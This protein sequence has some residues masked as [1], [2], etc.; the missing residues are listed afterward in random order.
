MTRRK[1][2]AEPVVRTCAD[3]KCGRPFPV[4]RDWQRFCSKKCRERILHEQMRR[5]ARNHRAQLAELA[6]GKS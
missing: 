5:D 1:P 3:P 2:A 6:G 4:H